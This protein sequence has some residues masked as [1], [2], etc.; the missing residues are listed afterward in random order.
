MEDDGVYYTESTNFTI[1][2]IPYPSMSPSPT[3][4][5]S[6]SQTPSMSKFPSLLPSSTSSPTETCFWIS[7][8]LDYDFYP[9]DT[10]YA[11][12]TSDGELI[13][14]YSETDW[15]AT[16]HTEFICLQEGDYRFVM[17][18]SW[19]NGI[20][21]GSGEGYYNVTSISK[22]GEFEWLIKEGGEF[23]R[24]DTTLFSIPYVPTS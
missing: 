4:L 21:C 10:S 15:E 5:P 6:A 16:S 22:G 13:Q 11:L 24:T 19:R 2:F 8:A 12:I 17:Y 7:I 20:C 14:S 23:E 3:E 1:P 9:L 18:D